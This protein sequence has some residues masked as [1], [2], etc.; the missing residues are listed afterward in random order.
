MTDYFEDGISRVLLKR[1]NES[2]LLFR[3]SEY[4]SNLILTERRLETLRRR[5]KRE[6]TWESFDPMI[7]EIVG[8]GIRIEEQEAVRDELHDHLSQ[9]SAEIEKRHGVNQTIKMF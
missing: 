9:L 5:Q 7:Q 3:I 1:L 8:I 2:D 4:Q 6:P